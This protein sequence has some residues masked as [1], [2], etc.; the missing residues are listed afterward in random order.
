[1]ARPRLSKR[2]LFGV[3]R[4]GPNPD[5]TRPD[6]PL[7]PLTIPNAIGLIRLALI[8]VFLIVALSSTDGQS[9]LAAAL[10]ALIIIV[11]SGLPSQKAVPALGIA[12]GTTA[13][14]FLDGLRYVMHQRAVLGVISLDLFAV[15]LG[16]AVA[17]LT[18]ATEPES[19]F[20][21]GLPSR[22]ALLPGRVFSALPHEKSIPLV[23]LPLTVTPISR[24]LD[25]CPA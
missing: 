8:P 15:L 24:S 23:G 3:D 21:G 25:T 22:S 18:E 14:R 11:G 4:S 9:A 13:S 10:F 20:A 6:Q 17:L 19:V 7:H 12:P 5:A 16:G 2:R 1:M